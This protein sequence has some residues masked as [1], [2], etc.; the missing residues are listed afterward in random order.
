VINSATPSTA[1]FTNTRR[2]NRLV[3]DKLIEGLPHFATGQFDS[4][5]FGVSISCAGDFVASPLVLDFTVSVDNPLVVENLPTG[6]VCD[7]VEVDD[8]RF[9]PSYSAST[10]EIV[11]DAPATS[12]ITNS[13]GDFV[14]LKETVA[15]ST[16]PIVAIE[17][18]E[19]QIVCTGPNGNTVFDEIRI[20][21]PG[22]STAGGAI[23]GIRYDQLPLL[24]QGT[25][26][27]VSEQNIPADWTLTTP[28]DVE[29]EIGSQPAPTI[30]FVN[31]HDTGSLEVT[32]STVGLPAGV[33]PEGLSFEV[34]VVCNHPNLPIDYEAGP[35]TL[36]GSDAVVIEDL[37]A[38]ASCVV[39]EADDV[40][41]TPVYSPSDPEVTIVKDGVVS[42]G[43]TNE[44]SELLLVKRTVAPTTHPIDSIETFEFEVACLN[45]GAEVYRQIHQVTT[46]TVTATGAVGMI[47]FDELPL[48]GAGTSCTATEI[49]S[50]LRHR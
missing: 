40:R 36:S 29:L 30:H 8:P 6:A 44:T 22:T 31:E 47:G 19:F 34:S 37:P 17:P 32:K 48:L 45:N 25:T 28:N 18:F 10:V 39:T 4:E 50:T 42:V 7:I 43:I 2:V 26:C 33:P 49:N 23:G 24:G 27:V 13:S 12:T 20:V 3:I 16:H 14:L 5:P 35:V 46:D 15:A 41:F 38:Q 11:E 9:T 21:E 1:A